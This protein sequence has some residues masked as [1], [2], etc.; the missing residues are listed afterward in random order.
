MNISHISWLYR[1]LKIHPTFFGYMP[2][3]TFFWIF[4]ILLYTSNIFGWIPR[5]SVISNSFK[6]YPTFFVNIFNYFA[7]I[8]LF[9]IF[10]NF[11]RCQHL[12]TYPTFLQF[13][14]DRSNIFGFIQF[15]LLY[16]LFLIVSNFFG[17]FYIKHSMEISNFFWIFLN[18]FRCI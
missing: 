5:S 16:Q 6:I 13:L 11:F 12:C 9:W 4:P 3:L 14:L 2:S 17:L 18:I 15:F 7:Y 8:Q 10:P 1:T